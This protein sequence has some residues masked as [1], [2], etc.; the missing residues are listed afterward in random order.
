[1]ESV[2]LQLV[3]HALHFYFHSYFLI[4]SSEDEHRHI[5]KT[6]GFNFSLYYVIPRNF[7]SHG[8]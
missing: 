8:P 3:M 4:W 6:N 2:C 5:H 7:C 1:M